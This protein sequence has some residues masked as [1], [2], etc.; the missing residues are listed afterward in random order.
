[1]TQGDP[2]RIW[3]QNGP[4]DPVRIIGPVDLIAHADEHAPG[5]ADPLTGVFSSGQFGD[6]AGGDYAEFGSDGT[7]ELFG[8][9]TYYEDLR[10]DALSARVGVVAPTDETGFR[11]NANFISRNFVNNQ[12]DEIQFPVQLPHAWM[13]GGEFFC[14]VHFSPWVVPAAPYAVQFILEYYWAN[15]EQQFP[16][17]AGS[18]TMTYTGNAAQ[19]F[20]IVATNPQ[21][22]LSGNK[23][24]SSVLKCRLY[25]DNTVVNN[26]PGRVALLY[27]D[28]HYQ[29]N[30]LGSGLEYLK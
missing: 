22:L 15:I 8:D 12:A 7:L 17:L 11:G 14:H 2:I 23:T 27:V 4:S 29:G 9:A 24:I 21:S 20:H 3:N 19:W 10:I 28:F 13:E 1:M 30:S 26:L 5:G 18:Y 6:V 25:R 16:A